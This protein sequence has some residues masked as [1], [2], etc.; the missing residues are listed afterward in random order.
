MMQRMDLRLGKGE[1]DIFVPSVKLALE[2]DGE[3]WHKNEEDDVKKSDLI[4][5]HGI[6]LIRIREPGCPQLGAQYSIITTPVPKGTGVYLAPVLIKLFKML[7]EMGLLFANEPEVDIERDRQNILSQYAGS[8]EEKTFSA[9]C[10][11]LVIEWDYKRNGSLKPENINA[12]SSQRVWWVC[13]NCGTEWSQII[14][15]RTN[16]HGCPQCAENKRVLSF[17]K[18]IIKQRGSFS[19]LFP[20]LLVEWDYSKNKIDPCSITS[21]TNI[22]VWW[23]CN[24]CGNEWEMSVAARVAGSGCPV[25]GHKKAVKSRIKT[26]LKLGDSFGDKNP[27]LVNELDVEKNDA[28]INPY[29][30]TSHSKQKAWW[31]CPHCGFSWEATF[32]SRTSGHGCPVCSNEKRVTSYL[33]KNLSDRGSLADEYPE[34]MQEWDYSKNSIDPHKITS[35]N[36]TSVWWKCVKCGHEWKTSPGNR[37]NS[38][39]PTGC[40]KCASVRNGVQSRTRNLVVG[41]ND[42]LSDNPELCEEWDY[43]QNQT[44]RPENCTKSSGQKVWWKCNVCHGTWQAT[45][46]NRNMLHSKCPYCS[47]KKVLVGFN[48]LAHKYP[49]IAEEWSESNF[50]VL[51]ND[52]VY[53]SHRKVFWTCS[54]CG[55]IWES[56]VRSRTQFGAECPCCKKKLMGKLYQYN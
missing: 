5:G 49:E 55:T 43:Q 44:L 34:L 8:I 33:E 47:N 37:T 22:S 56:E 24:T 42:L 50:P 31:K 39:N 20:E 38:K 4:I 3:H 15:S 53:S 45:I 14:A 41:V 25:C 26:L 11:E 52:V 27:D 51:P 12:F 17:R 2:Y 9:V 48:D 19:A 7:R 32:S 35:G 21:R 54:K 29:S 23:I 1:I 28:S 6:N 18:S 30:F 36:N 46:A 10:P 13:S 40:P 16:G